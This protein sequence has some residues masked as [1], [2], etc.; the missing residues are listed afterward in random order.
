MLGAEYIITEPQSD[1]DWENYFDLRC[2]ILRA[3]WNQPPGSE[4]DDREEKSIHLMI[5]DASRAPIGIGRLHLNSSDEAQV[6]FM[7][8]EPRFGGRGVGSRILSELEN[9]ARSRGATRVMLNARKEA[10]RFYLK[11]GYVI[12]GL[13]ET[14]FG[15]VEHVRMEKEISL[16]IVLLKR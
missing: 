14:L 2:R 11:H 16:R 12:V 10:T 3:P 8:V 1:A 13:A 4:R 6:R 5:C 7:A 9:R 15:T